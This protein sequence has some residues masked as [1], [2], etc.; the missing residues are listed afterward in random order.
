VEQSRAIP[1][2]ASTGLYCN[3]ADFD[4]IAN[5]LGEGVARNEEYAAIRPYTTAG[6]RTMA[7][8]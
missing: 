4:F 3:H 7:R 5:E 8:L 6:R 1:V 2:G